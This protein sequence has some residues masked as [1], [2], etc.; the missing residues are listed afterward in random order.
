RR[1]VAP[2]Q[3]VFDNVWENLG[4]ET[5]NRIARDML[6]P[7][8]EGEV[9]ALYLGYNEFRSA[10]AQGVVVEP[11]FPL[12]AS[13]I[14]EVSEAEH[15]SD[16]IFEPDRRALLERLVPMYVEITILRAL[17]E[18]MAS[19][20]GARMTAMDAATKNAAD[21]ISDLTLQYNRARQAAITT[22]LL[23]IISGA[24]ALSQG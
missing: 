20:L 18:S 9:D 24:E 19:E 16:F 5:A 17:Y 11:L 15:V 21:M 12:K 10:M 13:S 14:S 23:E 22:E 2:I 4:V 7:V 6:R 3:Q 1:R 8:L